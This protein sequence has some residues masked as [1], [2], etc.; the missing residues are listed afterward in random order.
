METFE[1]ILLHAEECT[2]RA[3]PDLGHS[4]RSTDLIGRLY[5]GAGAASVVQPDPAL[6]RVPVQ[7]GDFMHLE[8]AVRDI[9]MYRGDPQTGRAARQLLN[10]FNALLGQQRAVIHMGGTAAFDPD[11]PAPHAPAAPALPTYRKETM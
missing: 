11:A 7:R 6:A 9:E 8:W 10:R 2:R 5:Q 1:R 4:S 3:R